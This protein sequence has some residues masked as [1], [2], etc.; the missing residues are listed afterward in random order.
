MS[1]P[2]AEPASSPSSTPQPDSTP[3]AAPAS[4]AAP[5]G[6]K[7]SS[8]GLMRSAGVVAFM[9][10]L[11]RF[12][13]LWRFRILARLFGAT[14]VADAFN[15]AFIAPNL[16]RRLFGEGALTSAFV[17]VFSE[18]VARSDHEGANRTGSILITKVTY[19]LSLGCLVVIAIAAGVRFLLPKVAPGLA[20]PENLLLLDL[21]QWMLPYLI[22]INVACVLMAILNSLG[23]FWMPNFAPV[24]LNVMIIGACYFVVPHFGHVDEQRIWAVAFAVLIGGVLQL[25]IQFP[26]ALS[27]GF[28]FRPMV[29]VNDPGYREVIA[30]FKPVILLVGVFQANVLMDNIIAKTFIAG[31]GPVTYLNMGT[32]VYQMVW[33]IVALALATVSLPTLA[34]FWALSKKEDFYKTLLWGLRMAIFFTLP[35]TVGIMLLSDDIVR[36][37][38]GAGKFLENDAEPVRR[39]AGVALYSSLGLVFFSV[40]AL[41]A[42]ALYAMKDMKTPTTTSAW[43]VLINIFFNMFFV[44]GGNVVASA[45]HPLTQHPEE[46]HW[47]MNLLIGGLFALANIREGGIALASTISNGWQTWMLAKAVRARLDSN[48][49][50]S[51]EKTY[52]TERFLKEAVGSALLSAVLGVGVYAWFSHQKDWEGFYG[53]FAAILVSIVPFW[54]TC[55]NYFSEMMKPELAR[56]TEQ[57]PQDVFGVPDNRWTEDQKFQYCIYS[58]I[59]ASAIM[60]FVVWAMRDSLP[61]E[62][63]TFGLVLQRAIVPVATGVGVYFMA[64]SGLLSREYQE[65]KAVL[66]KRLRKS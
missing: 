17:P 57:S 9:T 34:K 2:A 12:L 7:D 31:S 53:F 18:Q 59:F 38:Y 41:L 25:L 61:P 28:R 47:V 63:R 64:A 32:S 60:G 55:R 5:I 33:S 43:S 15:F 23:H 10:I 42:R 3:A 66:F 62:G 21:F 36:L 6:H 54:L 40:N 58:S 44:V 48:P 24:L 56:Q 27:L 1:N 11:S 46:H 45:L 19:W 13:G 22:F 14:Y 49:A 16:T 50:T 51:T 8:H 20:T 65:F 37:L 29:D 52:S 35:C 4:V 30:N 26:P 39:T